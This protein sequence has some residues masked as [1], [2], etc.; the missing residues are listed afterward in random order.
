V[1]TPAGASD[2]SIEFA[3]ACDAVVVVL[4]PEPTSFMDA[5]AFIKALFL[6]KKVQTVSIV[7]NMAQTEKAAMTSFESFKKIVTKFLDIE[8]D[9]AGW[10]P[11]TKDMASSVVARKPVVIQK[12]L[13][14]GINKNF[15]E[16]TKSLVGLKPNKSNGVM[17]F[18]E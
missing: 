7:V 3:A 2:A 12:N 14:K 9:F 15:S 5:Y 8:I 10:L 18:N 4:V 13:D 1:D 16:I 6:E 11:S 17:F